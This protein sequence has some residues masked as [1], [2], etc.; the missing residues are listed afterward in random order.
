MQKMTKKLNILL[1]FADEFTLHRISKSMVDKNYKITKCTQNVDFQNHLFED[2]YDVV[3]CGLNLQNESAIELVK[4]YRFAY[5]HENN[6]KFF[7]FDLDQLADQEDLL[8]AKF[9]G[10]IT[11]WDVNSYLAA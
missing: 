4:V 8:D 11:T 1:C 6:T 7:L 3:I 5:P 9:D 2:V 10:R